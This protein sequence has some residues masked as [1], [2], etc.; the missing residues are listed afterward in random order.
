MFPGRTFITVKGFENVLNYSQIYSYTP[1]K[2]TLILMIK[3][4]IWNIYL[5]FYLFNIF[6]I[7]I[8][9]LICIFLFIYLLLKFI[10]IR[11]IN[12]INCPRI[13][14]IK[15][16]ILEIYRNINVQIILTSHMCRVRFQ[17]IT[18]HQCTRQELSQLSPVCRWDLEFLST[19]S[20]IPWKISTAFSSR[21][22]EHHFG[23]RELKSGYRK[24]AKMA[25]IGIIVIKKNRLQWKG[26]H[27]RM[28]AN[29]LRKKIFYFKNS[30]RI[31]KEKV[32]RR[33]SGTF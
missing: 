9:F 23:K 8:L 30:K 14:I 16:I 18:K 33:D 4:K 1:Q 15:K 26:D 6:D 31:W 24:K 12:T 2:Q 10:V 25:S 29:R 21:D 32:K 5:I 19:T 28:D 3:F 27:V 7:W 17:Q 22:L 20:E 13:I 11:Y